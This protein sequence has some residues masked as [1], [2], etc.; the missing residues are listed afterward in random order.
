MEAGVQEIPEAILNMSRS[1]RQRNPFSITK[2][3]DFSDQEILQFWVQTPN[4]TE[5]VDSLMQPTSPMPIF[6][7]GA[8]GSGKT[9]L[10]RYH[11]LQLQR[12]R[13]EAQGLDVKEGVASEGYVAIYLRCGGLNAGRFSG[14]RQSD[15]LWDSLFAYYVELW[16]AKHALEVAQACGS[17]ESEQEEE[18]LIR[19]IL[20]LFD[21]DP[22]LEEENLLALLAFIERERRHLD[23]Q[24]NN[25]VLT[26]RLDVEVSATRGRLVFG[27]PQVL[28]EHYH[29]LERA[30]FIY[31]IDELENLSAP[32]QRL[33]NSFVRDRQLPTTF[34]IGAR[35]YGI[36]TYRTDADQEENLP[37]SEF[38]KV[39]LDEELR[40]SKKEYSRFA[41]EVLGKRL[42]AVVYGIDIDQQS[43]EGAFTRQ[44]ETWD[45]SIFSDMMGP[46]PSRD[47]KHF[48]WLSEKLYGAGRGV[49]ADVV[50]HLSVH[51]YP[52]LEKANILSFCRAVRDAEDPLAVAR[53]VRAECNIFLESGGQDRPGNGVVSII[54]HYQSDLAAQLR[55][56]NGVKQYYL[57]LD[58]FVAMSSGIPRALLTI[59]RTVFDWAIYNGE[60]PMREGGVSIESQYRGV[61][62]ASEW[63]FTSMRQSGRDGTA[64]QSAVG[65]LAQIFRANRFSDL[66]VECSLNS[67]SIS[68]HALSE[69]SRRVLELCEK[70]SFVNRIPGG[71][72]HRNTM[73]V[74]MKFQL[75][76]MLCPRW[77]L[78]IARRG[79]MDLGREMA[80]A[81]FE[82]GR[83]DMFQKQLQQFERERRFRWQ[84]GQETLF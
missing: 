64:I 9:H 81:I 51:D 63:F 13:L 78:P 75:H 65:R 77:Q 38:K 34:R 46:P 74:Q 61:S 56:E 55:R 43:L 36:K 48:V 21:K 57:G 79:A 2:A 72:K 50:E 66:P 12:L 80:V 44:N 45:S 84:Q 6:L 7:L 35:S 83:H 20:A 1:P 69:E 39:I 31:A 73:E 47:R 67:F 52:L 17:T 29:C 25:C 8:K 59:L 76:P 68:E 71:Q 53:R 40:R 3:N 28:A 62:E 58:T 19:K 49:A 70:R 82:E 18:T 33:I 14:K 32:Q 26:G 60:D 23:M 24:V 27:I 15:D 10:M 37:E 30:T 5:D 54:E 41:R 22:V 4:V 16:L 42:S 11:S